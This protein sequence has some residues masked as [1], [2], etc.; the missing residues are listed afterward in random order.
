MT[1]LLYIHGFLSSPDSTKAR[2]TGDWIARHR[3]EIEF[4]CPEL[5]SYPDQAQRQLLAA[6]DKS[7]P[8][9][10]AV[11]GS[12]LGGFWATWLIEQQL[13]RRAVLINPA[14]TPQNLVAGLLHR[15]LQNYY[16]NVEYVLNEQHVEALSR[17]DC[18]NLRRPE[19]FWLM[20]QTGDE[21]LDYRHAVAKYHACRQTIESGGSHTFSG[22]ANWLPQI[23]AFLEH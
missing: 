6:I 22:Y 13:A 8:E 7:P 9:Q 23:I 11:I 10:T 20:V 14:V 15:P 5:S 17:C 4:I 2:Q 21:T 19:A 12:S 18:D 16:S 3:P 1:Y